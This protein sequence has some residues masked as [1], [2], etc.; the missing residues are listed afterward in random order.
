M[1]QIDRKS[2]DQG[3][4]SLV[5]RYEQNRSVVTLSGRRKCY[6]WIA[7]HHIHNTTELYIYGVEIPIYNTYSSGQNH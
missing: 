2:R 5:H 3:S 4:E 1:N 6:L 7:A